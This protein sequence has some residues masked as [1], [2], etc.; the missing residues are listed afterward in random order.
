[1]RRAGRID[2]NQPAIVQALTKAGACVTSMA[3]LGDGAADLLVSYRGAWHVIEIKNPLKP[4][5]G[6]KL[7]PD[8]VAWHRRQ[9]APIGV[10]LTAED[11]L[12]HIGALEGT[13]RAAMGDD[14]K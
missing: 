8:Q 6:R 12:R 10:V 3:S 5:S 13:S 9:H 7:T 4:P 11:A 14:W 1:M 2:E